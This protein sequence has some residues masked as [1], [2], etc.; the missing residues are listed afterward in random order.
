MIQITNENCW[1]W[2][3]IEPVHKSVLGIYISK[4][5]NMFV[6]EQFIRSLVEKYGKHIV[7]TDGGTWY[8]QACNFLRL[9]HSLH[10]SIEKSLIER[11]IQY[12]FK[13]KN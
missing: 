6:A 7:Y 5:R 8:T 1:L 11:V 9:K 2:V 10:S 13:K 4:E 12:Y 3:C